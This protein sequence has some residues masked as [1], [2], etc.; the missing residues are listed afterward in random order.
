MPERMMPE[1]TTRSR[2][3]WSRMRLQRKN[4]IRQEDLII[5]CTSSMGKK[6]SSSI[7]KKSKMANQMIKTKMRMK[8]S[9]FSKPVQKS[10]SNNALSREHSISSS[11]QTMRTVTMMPTSFNLAW[12]HPRHMGQTQAWLDC[13]WHQYR[14]A[15]HQV[16]IT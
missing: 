1:K 16:R 6:R 15:K 14:W 2:M 3:I 5:V 10:F 11:A 7:M 13:Q 8:T 9:R 12:H 4:W